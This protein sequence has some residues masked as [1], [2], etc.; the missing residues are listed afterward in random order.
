M[1]AENN[2]NGRASVVI[3]GG[4]AI[5]SAVAYFLT[6]SPD[7]KGRCV[8]I[9]RDPTY[10]TASTTLSCSSI[11]QQFSTAENVQI[12]LF[13]VDF[14]RQMPELLAVDGDRPDPQ[15]KE[16]GYLFLSRPETMH[17]L[18]ENH[19]VQSANGANITLLDQ[20]DLKVRF[21]WMMVDDLAGGAF[22]VQNEGWFDPSIFL[23]ALKRKAQSQGAEYITAQ[24]KLIRKGARVIGVKL[25]NGE[26][27]HSDIT[28]N[29]AGPHAGRLAAEAGIDLPVEAQTRTVFV[30][31]C[32][33]KLD[34]LPPLT[35]NPN[36]VYMRP[37]GDGFVS[38]MSPP[39][40][41]EPET[42]EL[43]PDW[44]LFEDF[45]WPTLAERI[46]AFEAIKAERAWAGHYDMNTVDH[47]AILG[48]HPEAPGLMLANGF[49]GHGIQQSPAVGRAISELILTGG[50]QTL[51]L[52]RF[53][54][55]RFAKGAL[56][57][58]KNVV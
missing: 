17:I 19:Q 10:T 28:V 22:G 7:F 1:T 43:E 57:I 15:F 18:E 47:N 13:G 36:G 50:Y 39:E 24:A 4:G 6:A 54:Y 49:S 14:L 21:P 34:P 8:V 46:P 26:T 33:E 30:I 56:I 51:D 37:E 25:S 11:R 20:A 2:A 32:R 23:G 53:G 38:G 29:C 27:I 40:G 42:A 41:R 48:A 9:E 16:R 35:I 52:S 3:V 5:G 58:E 44:S 55:D 31:K 12:G 45:I